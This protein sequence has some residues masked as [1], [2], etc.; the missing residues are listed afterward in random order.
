MFFF[1]YRLKKDIR[2]IVNMLKE[3]EEKEISSESGAKTTSG[4]E[5]LVII[6]SLVTSCI[7]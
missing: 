2:S 6:T 3:E 4:C 1:F 5:A 7:R